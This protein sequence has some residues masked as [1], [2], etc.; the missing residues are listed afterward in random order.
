MSSCHQFK[1]THI[2]QKS[3]VC[4]TDH[5]DQ[6]LACSQYVIS[7]VLF[8]DTGT[9]TPSANWNCYNKGSWWIYLQTKTT[10]MNIA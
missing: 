5:D 8:G 9:Y 4:T 7:T 10:E 2:Y 3:S 1:L 6:F